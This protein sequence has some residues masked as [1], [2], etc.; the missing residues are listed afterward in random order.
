MKLNRKYNYV[1]GSSTMDHGSRTY[2]IQGARLPSV[3]TILSKTKDDQFIKQWRQKVG[4]SEA[5]RIAN[6]SS[7]RGSAMHKFIEKY[8]KESGYEDLTPIGQEAKPMAEKIIEIGLAPVTHYYGAEVTLHYPGLYA[9]ATDLVCEHNAMDTIIDFKQTNRPKQREWIDDY[10]LQV[11]AYAMAHDYV[12]GSN[13]R[14]GIIMMCTP[15]HYYQEFVIQDAELRVWKHK[16]LKRLDS[17]YYLKNDYKEEAHI[18][19][20]ELLEEF[21]KEAQK[22]DKAKKGGMAKK[23]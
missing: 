22:L 4:Y 18:D 6:Y 13:I 11:A 19:T 20:H 12:Y 1:Q 10:F 7:L 2:E 16:F 14:Q 8:I 15:D 17:Y 3:T 21:E 9:G 5:E 23:L